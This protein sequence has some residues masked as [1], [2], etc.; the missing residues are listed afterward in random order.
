MP[1]IFKKV[2]DFN[3]CL[4]KSIYKNNIQTIMIVIITDSIIIS[5]EF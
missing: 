4:E 1:N 5:H 3:I 2:P